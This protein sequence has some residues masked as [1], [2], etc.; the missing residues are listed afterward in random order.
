MDEVPLLFDLTPDTTLDFRG[1]PEINVRVTS[2]YKVRATLVLAC[3]ADGSRLAPMLIFKEGNG[4][5]PKKIQEAYDGTR[6][7]LK[8]NKIGWMNKQS[9]QEWV[10]EVWVPVLKDDESYLLIYDSF[11]CHK[12]EQLMKSLLE[13]HLTEV[14][15]IPG[16]C[17]SVLQPRCW[18]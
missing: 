1:N 16:G 3:F 15:V 17:T 14:A 7:V 8:A 10:D 2:K 9:M 18:S 5:L 12:D 4:Q 13:N 6:I 11:V